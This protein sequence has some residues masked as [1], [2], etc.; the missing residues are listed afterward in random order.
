ME[1]WNFPENW[2]QAVRYQN[3]P[4]DVQDFSF[5]AS[6]MHLSVRMKDMDSAAEAPVRDL[7]M[8]DPIAWEATG[9]SEDMVEPL[10]VEADE[11]L[12]SAVETFFPEY[13]QYP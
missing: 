3:E 4:A 10:L 11:Q 2:I 12:E 8:I 1:S 6:I 7:T 5:E 9:L 13:R